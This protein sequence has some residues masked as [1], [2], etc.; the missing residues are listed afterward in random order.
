MIKLIK[1]FQTV[2][3]AVM[4]PVYWWQY[5]PQNFLWISDTALIVGTVALWREDRLL[6][7]ME[8]LSVFVFEIA[9]GIDMVLKLIVG[10]K[11]L[12]LSDYM[13][14]SEIP[15][16]IRLLSLFHLWMPWLLVWMVLQYGYDRRALVLQTVVWWIVVVCSYMLATPDNNINLVLGVGAV[17]SYLSEAGYLA[18]IV[19]GMPVLNYL[20]MHFFLRW[21]A[22]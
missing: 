9:W 12:G 8:A 2:F 15:L 10:G 4:V 19:V 11:F 7:S 3:V 13:F 14:K 5:G 18:L 22:G 1:I 17:R 21:L 16:W 6:A 20:P